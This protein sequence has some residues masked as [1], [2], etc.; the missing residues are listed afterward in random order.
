M[1]MPIIIRSVFKKETKNLPKNA[2]IK[3]FTGQLQNS[4]YANINLMLSQNKVVLWS[5]YRN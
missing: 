5:P 4:F 2:N 3:N 1:K